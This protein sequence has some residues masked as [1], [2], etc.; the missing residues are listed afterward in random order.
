MN[1]Q[2][3]FR[4]IILEYVDSC[5]PTVRSI[6]SKPIVVRT[7]VGPSSQTANTERYHGHASWT[8]VQSRES[9]KQR[10]LVL[11]PNVQLTTTTT[12]TTRRTNGR[13]GC[14]FGRRNNRASRWRP[15]LYWKSSLD[16]DSGLGWFGNVSKRRRH[17][18]CAECR[19]SEGKVDATGGGGFARGDSAILEIGTVG[20]EF[21]IATW[22][23]RFARGRL[24]LD[25]YR[26]F[27]LV[28]IVELDFHDNAVGHGLVQI[29]FPQRGRVSSFL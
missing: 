18:G 16:G 15:P 7:I 6:C 14:L 28:V 8:V 13:H 5:L 17:R 12:T 4:N 11:V 20:G 3:S 23:A 27:A 19:S 10:R 24:V 1:D 29:D 2:L 22:L 25:V 9:Y 21:V 26:N